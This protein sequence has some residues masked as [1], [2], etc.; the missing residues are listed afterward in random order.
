MKHQI[1]LHQQVLFITGASSG[2]GL[3]T[4]HRA[5]EQG[6]KVFMTASREDELQNVQDEMR[7]NGYQ[8]AFSV[9][10]V[11]EEDQIQF[12]VDQCL[13]TFGRIDTFINNAGISLYG[14][15]LDIPIEEARNLFDTNFWGVVN[16]S[17]VALR[18][19]KEKGG[20][21]INIG[22]SGSQVNF[23]IQGFYDASKCA[24]KA[25]TEALRREVLK[26]K[27]PI[28]VIL[29]SPPLIDTPS[30]KEAY[31]APTRSLY[32]PPMNEEDAVAKA[33]LS[34]AVRPAKNLRVTAS[35]LYLRLMNFSP[36]IVLHLNKRFRRLKIS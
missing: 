25:F 8:T 20:T 35:S 34:C 30:F 23:P 16:G 33:I 1:P 17:R 28:Q 11:S 5:V 29:L 27:L 19:F 14:K 22:P 12:A 4:V 7:K 18:I 26:E 31:A 24:V 36:R 32:R 21:I 9:I 10:D 15:L 3:A 2:V 6:A 13:K